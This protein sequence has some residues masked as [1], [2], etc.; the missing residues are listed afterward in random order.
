[1]GHT[2]LSS[3]LNRFVGRAADRGDGFGDVFRRI[4]YIN[5]VCCVDVGRNDE[6]IPLL[7]EEVWQ[8]LLGREEMPALLCGADVGNLRLRAEKIN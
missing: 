3:R 6:Q 1:M 8:L 7:A 2:R 5:G 4:L